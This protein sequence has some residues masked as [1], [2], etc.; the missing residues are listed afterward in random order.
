MGSTSLALLI[1]IPAEPNLLPPDFATKLIKTLDSQEGTTSQHH[2]IEPVR[3]GLEAEANGADVWPFFP[4]EN[5][6]E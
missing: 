1:Q 6:I 2:I 4:G 3:R 5:G